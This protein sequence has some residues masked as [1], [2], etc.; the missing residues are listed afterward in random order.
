MLRLG[1]VASLV[2]ISCG[3]SQEARTAPPKT[4]L[5]T[6]VERP[7]SPP[8]PAAPT[9]SGA[10]A[11]GASAPAPAEPCTGGRDRQG[12]QCV[13]PAQQA[14]RRDLSACRPVRGNR[15]PDCSAPRA[16][17]VAE[18]QVP[19]ACQV[20]R[21]A[22]PRLLACYDELADQRPGPQG[23]TR[24]VMKLASDGSVAH[25][26]T[27]GGGGLDDAMLG[28]LKAEALQLVFAPPEAGGAVLTIPLTFVAQ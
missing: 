16:F 23:S 17:Q 11:A 28:C 26:V 22:W 1:L 8:A 5:D 12:S 3:P 25:A 20:L 7:A 18:G 14:W 9:A 15:P 21:A 4:P 2:L 27:S 19:G 13:C 24:I 10:P 6:P